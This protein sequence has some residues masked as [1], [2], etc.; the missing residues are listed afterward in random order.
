MVG[1]AVGGADEMK[2]SFILPNHKQVDI[3][4][5]DE[6]GWNGRPRVP[7]KLP[8]PTI[9]NDTSKS[10]EKRIRTDNLISAVSAFHSK[11]PPGSWMD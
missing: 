3:D 4:E 7:K 8:P 2:L 9:D 10:V 11:K 6:P 5:L 1:V